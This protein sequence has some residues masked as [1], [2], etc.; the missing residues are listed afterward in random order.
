MKIGTFPGFKRENGEVGIRNTILIMYTVNCSR[1]VAQGI[2]KTARAEGIPA[3]VV[4]NG[5]CFDNQIIIHKMLRLIAHGNIGAVLL[6][7][8][9]CEFIQAGKLERFAKDIKK[10]ISVVF[11]Q[12]HGTTACIEEGTAKVRDLWNTIRTQEREDIPISSLKVG[13]LASC[14]AAGYE[15]EIKNLVGDLISS[16]AACVTGG[17]MPEG[18]V[19]AGE[20]QPA[21][22]PV[23]PGMWYL[24]INQQD[25]SE[26]GSASTCP[27]D[28]AMD[29]ICCACQ[30]VLYPMSKG[31]V[32]GTVVSPVLSIC[33]DR[34][35]ATQF[36]EEIDCII[37]GDKTLKESL[38]NTVK[39]ALV[40]AELLEISEG[41]LFAL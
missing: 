35:I 38:L 14:G 25:K 21:Q 37:P 19:S 2:C 17:P 20:L 33:S 18:F 10:P 31:A 13:L 34:S 23:S 11:D 40:K 24:N 12:D 28:K 29:L 16:G 39:G 8:H 7:G 30:L 6:V 41:N 4:G 22:T 32:I 9:G 5:S 26:L 15:P 36:P 27:T 1:F 3:Q